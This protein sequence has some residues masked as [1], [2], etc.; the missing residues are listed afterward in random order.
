MKITL[1]KNAG[2]CFGVKRATQIAFEAAS[3]DTVNGTYTLGP[4]IHSPQVVKKLE[5]IKDIAELT[6]LLVPV[7]A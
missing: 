1:A 3:Q 6:Q 4:I 2:F 5:D 7:T